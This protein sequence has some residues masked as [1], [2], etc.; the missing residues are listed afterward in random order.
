MPRLTFRSLITRAKLAIVRA[1]RASRTSRRSR[2]RRS[3]T[4]KIVT[5]VDGGNRT[6]LAARILGE[7]LRAGSAGRAALVEMV[8]EF[9]QEAIEYRSSHLKSSVGWVSPP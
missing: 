3:D 7:A 1:L 6:I 8:T 9:A 4:V 2:R 5:L